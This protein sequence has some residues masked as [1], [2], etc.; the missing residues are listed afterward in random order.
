MIAA[1]SALLLL[2]LPVSALAEERVDLFTP[3]GTRTG[4][5]IVDRQRGRVDFYDAE[6]RRTG[7]GRVHPS[8]K[9]DQFD[10]SG[11]RRGETVFPWPGKRTWREPRVPRAR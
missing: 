8:G 1:L 10:L 7:W 9:V 2:A 11:R 5:A 4:Y 6:S 3:D